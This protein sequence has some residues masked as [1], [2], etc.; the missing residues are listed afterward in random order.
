MTG[1]V[2]CHEG[3]GALPIG[4]YKIGGLQLVNMEEECDY[5]YVR[6]HFL[7]N[8]KLNEND[9]S[10]EDKEILDKVIEKFKGYTAS[11]ISEY[12]H[13]EVTYKKTNDKEII[14]F[15][16]AKQIRDF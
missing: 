5:E 7:P 15:S 11:Q 9:L 13:D 2:Y 14:P 10:I 1:L 3:M 4:H 16:L 12:M 8:E 6:Y